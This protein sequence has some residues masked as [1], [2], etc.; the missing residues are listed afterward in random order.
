MTAELRQVEAGEQFRGPALENLSRTQ[1]VQYACASGDFNPLHT[2][3]VY[4][5]QVAGYQTVFAHGMLTMGALGRVVG[6]LFGYA[7][8]K[9]FG[10]RFKAQVWPGDDVTAYLTVE[11]VTEDEA[12]AVGQLTVSGRNQA[13][14]EVF[15]G[16]AVVQAAPKQA[17]G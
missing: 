5:T 10:G 9:S 2:D 12:G 4:A 13:G 3:E 7:N 1:I 11:A 17:T 16:A 6:E 15:L 14:V 8:I